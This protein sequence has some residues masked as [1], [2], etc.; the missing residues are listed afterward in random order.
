M[1]RLLNQGSIAFDQ[2]RRNFA[3]DRHCDLGRD[4]GPPKGITSDMSLTS[5]AAARAPIGHR[6]M[7]VTIVVAFLGTVAIERYSRA[8]QRPSLTGIK[9]S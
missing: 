7:T 8:Q 9:V 1:I 6:W 3:E 2:I 4:H 5:F